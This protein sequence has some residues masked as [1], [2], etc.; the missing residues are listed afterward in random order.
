M[1]LTATIQRH[2][3]GCR[4]QHGPRN[5]VR[6]T[7]NIRLPPARSVAQQT[8]LDGADM[9]A[10]RTRSVVKLHHLG[11]CSCPSGSPAA[12]SSL[13]RRTAKYGTRRSGMRRSQMLYSD[14]LSRQSTRLGGSS[15]SE[16]I[17]M[18]AGQRCL[19]RRGMPRRQECFWRARQPSGCGPRLPHTGRSQTA[20]FLVGAFGGGLWCRQPAGKR[21]SPVQTQWKA[22]CGRSQPDHEPKPDRQAGLRARDRNRDSGIARVR[23]RD[24][25]FG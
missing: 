20:R 16:Q 11:G 7:G 22:I 3:Q 24:R 17:R 14:R 10:L 21:A 23:P 2:A 1:R 19:W 8:W 6:P 25:H 9:A 12:G 15:F 13:V 18:N 4:S 5:S